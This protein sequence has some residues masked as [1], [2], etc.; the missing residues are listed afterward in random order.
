MIE[1]NAH[2]GVAGY[3]KVERT[4]RKTGKTEVVMDFTRNKLTKLGL[5]EIGENQYGTGTMCISNHY[6]INDSGDPTDG[7][8]N[9]GQALET[10]TLELAPETLYPPY[11]YYVVND[12]YALPFPPYPY[13]TGPFDAI[14]PGKINMI[15]GMDSSTVRN[16]Y[17]ATTPTY[18][19]PFYGY[20]NKTFRFDS[21]KEIHIKCMGIGGKTNVSGTYYPNGKYNSY[22]FW[23]YFSNINV[24]DEFGNFQVTPPSIFE[25]LEK[26]TL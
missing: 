19:E 10:S 16:S 25:E 26:T 4:N 9:Q 15:G 14:L 13:P 18:Q 7:A 3:Y 17:I 5:N 22:S 2:T 6:I 12:V 20:Y 24:R 23:S 1:L 8:A 11:P 21:D